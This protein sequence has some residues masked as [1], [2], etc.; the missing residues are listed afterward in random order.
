MRLQR[1]AIVAATAATFLATTASADTSPKLGTFRNWS[2]YATG[3]GDSRVCY[4]S[5]A[6]KRSEPDKI[7]RNAIFFLINDWPGRGA[8][9]EAEIV[10]GYEYKDTSTVTVEVGPAKFE[11]FTKNDAGAGAAWVQDVAEE[12]HLVEAMR[13][14]AEMIVIGTSKRGTVTRDTFSLAGLTDAL[15]HAHQACGL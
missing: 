1:I 5:S 11:F 15:D 3:T 9:S 8:K 7:K 10:P 6:P 4:A 2:A 14:G 13:R 12:K